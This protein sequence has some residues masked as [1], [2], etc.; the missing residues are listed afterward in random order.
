MKMGKKIYEEGEEEDDEFIGNGNMIKR[1]LLGLND[2]EITEA[3]PLN[4][5]DS[6]DSDSTPKQNVVSGPVVEGSEAPMA[7]PLEVPLPEYTGPP[8]KHIHWEV[9]Y[10]HELECT[11]WMEMNEIEFD[12]EEFIELFRAQAV[13]KLK[14]KKIKTSIICNRSKILQY[15]N[16]IKSLKMYTI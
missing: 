14:K 7:P 16:C 15:R 13:K 1:S 4:D 12:E 9:L 3:V 11:I 8:M 10:K 5:S 2:E 6:S